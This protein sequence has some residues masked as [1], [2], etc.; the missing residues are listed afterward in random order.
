MK[1]SYLFGA[2]FLAALIYGCS[3]NP[4]QG[5]QEESSLDDSAQVASATDSAAIARALEIVSFDEI[6]LILLHHA[7]D[8][9]WE[10]AGTSDPDL[11]QAAYSYCSALQDL[12]FIITLPSES[13]YDDMFTEA[14]LVGADQSWI[15]F[16]DLISTAD[17]SAFNL[18][19][20]Q[21]ENRTRAA[22][23]CDAFAAMSLA[24]Y[25]TNFGSLSEQEARNVYIQMYEN[26]SDYS[27]CDSLMLQE[28]IR[29][30]DTAA[31][32]Y[33]EAVERATRTIITQDIFRSLT[34]SVEES[35]GY[36]PEDQHLLAVYEVLSFEH[37]LMNLSSERETQS[38]LNRR[39]ACFEFVQGHMTEVQQQSPWVLTEFESVMWE[40]DQQVE[41]FLERQ[42]RGRYS[43]SEVY[44]RDDLTCALSSVIAT[45]TLR[46]E[47]E[48]YNGN[49]AQAARTMVMEELSSYC[50]DYSQ[51]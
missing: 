46:L 26:L 44:L 37:I 33:A 43:T 27:I 28:A 1:A 10:I 34:N 24:I 11:E 30:V 8:C 18:V 2:A 40:M 39:R 38:E 17:L 25:D 42:D 41:T 7:L 51:Y 47:N 36:S 31:L 9:G 12:G 14:F 16:T 13:Q 15:R 22:I 50:P 32:A 35:T 19:I 29:S 5:G 45:R 48:G 3:E 49:T 4:R 21:T 20:Q 6:D 23:C